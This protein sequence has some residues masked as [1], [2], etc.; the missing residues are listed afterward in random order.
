[1]PAWDFLLNRRDALRVGALAL[2]GS[3]GQAAVSAETSRRRKAQSVI[4]L[5]MAGGVTHL[6]S[7]DPKPDAPQEVRGS[8]RSIATTLPTV[9]FCETLPF[10][11]RQAHRLALVRSFSSGTDDHFL[12][13]AFAL[14]GRRVTAAQI[15]TEPNVGSIVAKLHGPR[16]GLPG[17]LAVPG[18]TRPGPPPTSLFTGDWLGASMTPSAPAAG[19]AMRTSPL[20]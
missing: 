3:L 15:L 8:L 19:R 4:V 6:D 2:A 10:L 7:F 1:L 14:S 20:G 12:S 11:A 9:L 5:W 16:A 13:Q 18:T 17:Y